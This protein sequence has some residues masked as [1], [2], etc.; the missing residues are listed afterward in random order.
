MSIIEWRHNLVSE[1]F[2]V[3]ADA[4][5]QGNDKVRPIIF[6]RECD[7]FGKIPQT[8]D[9][10]IPIIFVFVQ[11]VERGDNSQMKFASNWQI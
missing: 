10:H 8:I 11:F 2:A 4:L 1:V 9:N 6:A 7:F 3:F 5:Q